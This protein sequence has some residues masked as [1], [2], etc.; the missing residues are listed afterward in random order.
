MN[1]QIWGYILIIL[2]LVACGEDTYYPAGL[3]GYQVECLLTGG[4]TKHWFLLE[5]NVDGQRNSIETCSD[6]VWL[7]FET[8]GNDSIS[9]YELHFDNQCILFDT[10]IVGSLTASGGKALFKDTLYF[11]RA[12]GRQTY[13][14]VED[15]TSENLRLNYF[16]SGQQIACYLKPTPAKLMS[17]QVPLFLAGEGSVN[18]YKEWKL[19]RK[20]AGAKNVPLRS[21]AD[22][23][24]LRF[25]VLPQFFDV[26]EYQN[27]TTCQITSDFAF[28]DVVA[29]GT[30]DQIYFN[31]QLTLKGGV[32]DEL[33]FS[34]LTPEAFTANYDTIQVTYK[35]MQ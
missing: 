27:D 18:S 9:T 10:V 15:V 5:N 31:N 1:K 23:T 3:Y 21:C 35:V 8:I 17:R 13:M 32:F 29:I 28:G 34:S 33:I 14:L 16:S 26:H 22:S 11:E 19:T 6:S 2:G 20:T 4:A 24:I 30:E 7:V 25:S 12:S